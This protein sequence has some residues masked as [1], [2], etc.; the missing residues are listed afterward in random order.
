M[1]KTI[2]QIPMDSDL[3]KQAQNMAVASGFSSV[4]E[5]VRVFLHK[6]AHQKIEVKLLD[7]TVQLS[8]AA[9]KRYEK[10]TKD[11]EEGRNIFK[12]DSVDEL[13]KQ[14]HADTLS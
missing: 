9:E 6:F 2:L 14:L 4:Q 11:I 12:A 8:P 1:N 5:V 13:M 3:K 10:I 7:T